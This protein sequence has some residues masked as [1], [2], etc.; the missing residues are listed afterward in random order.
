[1]KVPS[2]IIRE[3]YL[4][5]LKR[6][7]SILSTNVLVDRNQ[8]MSPFKMSVFIETMIRLQ[9]LVYYLANYSDGWQDFTDDVEE[10]GDVKNIKDL[11][12]V[13]RDAAVHDVTSESVKAGDTGNV[14]SKFNSV[15]GKLRIN[16][17][18]DYKVECDY[19]DD[20]AIYYGKYRI[21]LKRHVY[22]IVDEAEKALNE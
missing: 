19:N 15:H 17:T 10:I 13:V 20:V 7:K 3:R 4:S 16:L 9:N 2:R 6:L 21:Y 22:R 14:S 8:S 11:V 1:M 12:K 5:E 18:S